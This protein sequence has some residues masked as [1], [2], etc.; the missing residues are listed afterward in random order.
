M[1][2]HPWNFKQSLL[3]AQ[4]DAICMGDSTSPDRVARKASF[5]E[6]AGEKRL[7]GPC[8]TDQI[9]ELGEVALDP[10]GWD[11]VDLEPVG[12]NRPHERFDIRLTTS[13]TSRG[14]CREYPHLTTHPHQFA[15]RLHVEI[16]IE[17]PMRHQSSMI[18]RCIEEEEV[19]AEDQ[20]EGIIFEWKLW[21]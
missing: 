10:V 12:R 9:V 2:P 11:Q 1:P 8:N 16:E 19:T 3:Y 13:G 5:A 4:E 7:S 14:E 6:D 21:K 17:L 18:D 20:I 15:N